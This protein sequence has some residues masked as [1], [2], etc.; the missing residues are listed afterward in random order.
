MVKLWLGHRLAAGLR[1][2]GVAMCSLMTNRAG[3]FRSGHYS[4][5]VLLHKDT[6]LKKPNLTPW[7][8][9]A[10]QTHP[11]ELLNTPIV[12]EP[13]FKIMLGEGHPEKLILEETYDL[14][15]SLNKLSPADQ[16]EVTW[17]PEQDPQYVDKHTIP[18]ITRLTPYQ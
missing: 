17:M 8:S 1:Q 13:I 9:N 12:D 2:L 4:A 3:R 6:S 10:H 11:V 5:T 15:C 18:S 16:L 7:T 14:P